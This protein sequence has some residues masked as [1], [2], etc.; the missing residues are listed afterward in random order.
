MRLID[1]MM[2]TAQLL[3]DKPLRILPA[4]YLMKRQEEPF[5]VRELTP[6]YFGSSA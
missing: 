3:E 4:I 6:I 5:S 1:E 2:F